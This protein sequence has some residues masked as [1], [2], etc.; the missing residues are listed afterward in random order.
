MRRCLGLLA[1]CSSLVFADECATLPLPSVAVKR[2]QERVAMNFEYGIAA[3]DNLGGPLARPGRHVLG[4]TRAQASASYEIRIPMVV[5]RT[6]R[7]ECAS[8]QITLTYGFSPMTIYVAR[9]FPQGSCAHQEIY[10]HELR[11]VNTYREHATRIEGVL[12]ERLQ[13][14]FATGAPWRGPAG[15]AQ[16]RLQRELD[17]RWL[18]VARRMLKE[19]ESRQ[20]R[21]D[22]A[23]EYDRV[24]ASC[25]GEVRKRLARGVPLERPQRQPSPGV[26]NKS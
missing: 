16:T 12:L 23:D 21:I 7:W 14:R 22:T 9:E 24:A 5:D 3:L 15:Q 25:G 20:A 10:E 8:P 4:L 18:P 6:G 17:E 1:F 13:Q 26:G 2:L 19:A 11:H